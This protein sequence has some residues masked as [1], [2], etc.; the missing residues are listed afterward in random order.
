MQSSSPFRT[1]WF[2]PLYCWFF[3][4]AS[5][6]F[7]G[8]ILG[9]TGWLNKTGYL[10]TVSVIGIVVFFWGR[11][12]R[13]SC[14]P[15]SWSR[16]L[17]RR[18]GRPLPICFSILAI[19]I[20][21]SGLI[22][23]P[24][25]YD[26]LSYRIPRVLN[27]LSEGN[28]HW[29]HTHDPR[30]NTRICGAEWL[31]APWIALTGTDRWIFLIN[32]SAFLLLP[33]LVFSVFYRLGVKPRVAWN[34]MWLLPTGYHFALQAGGNAND[35]LGS[36]YALAAV[37]F[38]LRASQK[39]S[40]WDGWFAMVAAALLTSSKLSNLPL[41]LPI[42]LALL[43][44]TRC[45][46]KRP[47]RTAAVCVIAA[48]VSLLPTAWINFTHC[49]DW[50]GD[51][52][53]R[54]ADQ[55]AL[56]L[57]AGDDGEKVQAEEFIFK[58]K[59]PL[60]GVSVNS[61]KMFLDNLCPPVFPM[62]SWWNRHVLNWIPGEWRTRLLQNFAPTVFQ[63]R[64]LQAEESAGLGFGVSW[65]LLISFIGS[66]ILARRIPKPGRRVAI[67]NWFLLASPYISILVFMSKIGLS[68]N[69]RIAGPYYAL[70]VPLLVIGYSW[71]TLVR[72]K[73]WKYAAIGVYVVV[74]AA[75][76]VVPERPLLPVR[77][78]LSALQD[79]HPQNPLIGRA[80][81]VYALYADRRNVLGEFRTSIPEGEQTIG[82]VAYADEPCTALWRPF[83]S[84]QVR[85]AMLSDSRE[86][87]NKLGIRFLVVRDIGLGPKK[88]V[89]SM[90]GEIVEHR[91]VR[92]WAAREA[93]SW[94]LVKLQP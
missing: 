83:G 57:P 60:I 16:Q 22:H 34:W 47:L 68:A 74:F 76:A 2:S 84:R 78:I 7:F 37:N 66:V 26:A 79:Q 85:L 4:V 67:W 12:A 93:S 11:S 53:E 8:W 61:I 19:L 55:A 73:G 64:E 89:E 20:L 70:L 59:D 52:L 21:I 65:I 32:W 49:G 36:L 14:T 6:N 1:K 38:A 48:T 13:K 28:W 29:I 69:T 72:T 80:L 71:S 41:L 46:L 39:S 81:R 91:E 92:L 30:M 25:N 5:F 15:F 23:G 75:L 33:G 90:R 88:W 63:Q 3:V 56:F 62:A 45:L 51:V 43:P 9:A 58:V 44:A 27:W 42:A 31:I 77:P 40:A 54:K 82:F 86:Y 50:S 35:I 87:L 17:K 10:L 24:N 18:L 94:W